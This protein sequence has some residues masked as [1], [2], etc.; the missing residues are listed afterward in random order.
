M[1]YDI[2]TVFS[3][4]EIATAIIQLTFILVKK[5]DNQLDYN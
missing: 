1:D 3:K 2:L 4:T 5:I